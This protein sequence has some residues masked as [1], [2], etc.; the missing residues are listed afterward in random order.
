MPKVLTD[1]QVLQ[2][3][4]NGYLFPLDAL[5]GNEVVAL[6]SQLAATE[7]QL[8]GAL[9]AVEPKYRHNLHLLCPWMA[10]LVREPCIVDVIEDLLGPD[11]LLYTSRFFIRGPLL[12]PLLP[13]IRI[14]LILGSAPSIMLP[15]G[16]R[17]LTY[18]WKVVPSNLP[19]VATSVVLLT[20]V[21]KW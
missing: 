6:R 9:M 12:K 3:R 1:E 10:T 19:V 13:G 8:G 7:D 14:A 11:I 15:L 17:F 21:A 20:S 16:W 5:N 2:Y 4:A 18:L